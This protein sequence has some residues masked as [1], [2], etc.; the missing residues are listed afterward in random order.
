M[1]RRVHVVTKVR[2][3]SRK[4]VV[5]K[6][7]EVLPFVNCQG[8]EVEC[9]GPFVKVSAM[10]QRGEAEGFRKMIRG[11]ARYPVLSGKRRR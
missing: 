5:E 6:I 3:A 8:V 10:C 9:A 2:C 1:S 4:A 11:A 7:H